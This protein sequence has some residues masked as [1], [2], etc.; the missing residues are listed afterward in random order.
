MDG[1]RRPITAAPLADVGP[2]ETAGSVASVAGALALDGLENVLGVHLR[3]AQAIANREFVELLGPLELTQKQT[4]VLWLVGAN[5][6]VSQVEIAST[7][8]MDRATTMAIVDRLD[9]RG[10]LTRTRSETDG[11]RRDLTLTK[12]GADTLAQARAAVA[13]H[14]RRLSAKLTAHERDVLIT[15]L[16]KLHL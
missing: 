14:E 11:R 16:K 9:A 10:L 13:E 8:N 5:P 7:I 2:V 4:A 6:G 15:A 3:M 12:T 1:D